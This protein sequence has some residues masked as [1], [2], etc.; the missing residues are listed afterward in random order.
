M[1]ELL[2][3]FVNRKSIETKEV[4]PTV[5]PEVVRGI[6][7][8]PAAILSP[9]EMESL[10]YHPD[11]AT[12]VFEGE[13]L[14]KEMAASGTMIREH[15]K[16][17]AAISVGGIQR[18]FR[19]IREICT[20]IED[21]TSRDIVRSV[22]SAGHLTPPLNRGRKHHYDLSP[23]LCVPI[24]GEGELWHIQKPLVSSLEELKAPKTDLTGM[25]TEP[26]FEFTVKPG[27]AL[28]LPAGFRHHTHAV[29]MLASALTV[30]FLPIRGD[31][32]ADALPAPQWQSATSVVE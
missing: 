14:P 5:E 31:L 16:R 17:G 18:Y 21:M 12:L 27:D 24:A 15:F 8:D 13:E 1:T 7:A 30:N 6:I 4:Y 22:V 19:S 10:V 32:S 23:T 25:G 28:Y 26:D 11:A 20:E 9:Q 2:S 29:G 3:E